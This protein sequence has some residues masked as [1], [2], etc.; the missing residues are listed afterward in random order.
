M[1]KLE[2]LNNITTKQHI[3]VGQL[4]RGVPT[5]RSTKFKYILNSVR[6]KN[7]TALL[8]T[9]AITVKEFLIQCSHA[10]DSYFEQEL[11]WENETQSSDEEVPIMY[12]Q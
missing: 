10:T 4:A 5:T 2:N 3:I 12:P 1:L 6:I 9:G 8:T 11:S 7:S